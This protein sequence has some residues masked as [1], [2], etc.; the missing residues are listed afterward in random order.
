MSQ[1]SKA[2]Q[3]FKA[4]YPD[5]NIKVGDLGQSMIVFVSNEIFREHG[6]PYY[7]ETQDVLVNGVDIRIKL[8]S[9]IIMSMEVLN[10][11]D[12]SYIS[13]QRALRIRRNLRGYS[14]KAVILSFPEN[15]T[16]DAKKIFKR[17]KIPVLSL[18]FQL[19]PREIHQ[20]IPD[21]DLYRRRSPNK[22]T[23]KA[24]KNRL[25]SF[26]QSIGL[27]P[28]VYQYKRSNRRSDS[29]SNYVSG[30][31]VDPL[32]N[33]MIKRMADHLSR[34]LVE[35]QVEPLALS[36]FNHVSRLMFDL[37]LRSLSLGEIKSR[38]HLIS[39][40]LIGG[41]SMPKNL[42][43]KILGRFY[44][45]GNLKFGYEVDPRCIGDRKTYVHCYNC[46]RRIYEGETI[47]IQRIPLLRVYRYYC[48]D[49]FKDF[50]I[51]LDQR[52]SLIHI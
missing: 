6:L 23:I 21:Q 12:T 29:R 45:K 33:S 9:E 19:L 14:K 22:R 39:I 40:R 28:P 41:E 47:G 1:N 18:N 27:I 37:G 52:L 17:S 13:K 44:L 46:G 34:P 35:R 32:S 5:Y 16:R 50:W 31:R 26:F 25:T 11:Q 15:L 24:L 48:T 38:S 8:G 3:Q 43:E 4:S 51:D 30:S 49:C 36:R 2:D 42:K 7:A 20:S 10:L